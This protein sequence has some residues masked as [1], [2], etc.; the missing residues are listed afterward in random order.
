MVLKPKVIKKIRKL[1]FEEGLS[2]RLIAAKLRL[3]PTT[4]A[5]HIKDMND[6][7]T[8][9]SSKTRSVT[10]EGKKRSDDDL[11]GEYEMLDRII[12]ELTSSQKRP[13]IV[14]MVVPYLPNPRKGLDVLAEALTLAAINPHEKEFILRNWADHVGIKDISRYIDVKKKEERKLP[15][16]KLDPLLEQIYEERDKYLQ[17]TLDLSKTIAKPEEKPVVERFPF[18]IDGMMLKL[19][20]QELLEWKKYVAEREEARM[21]RE[22]RRKEEERLRK[23]LAQEKEEEERRKKDEE[24]REDARRRGLNV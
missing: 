20:F 1:R 18:V 10:H 2:I 6:E 12:S 11:P 5:K 4:V 9:I 23:E 16:K 19:T 21:E 17:Q 14:R 3:S 24:W 22:E 15:E 7:E 13:A 8:G